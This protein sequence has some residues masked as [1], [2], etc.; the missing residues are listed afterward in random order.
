MAEL[1]ERIELNKLQGSDTGWG[2]TSRD[3]LLREG[4]QIALGLD[5]FTWEELG[6]PVSMD[7]LLTSE[8]AEAPDPT[9]D[10]LR[11]VGHA[12]RGLLDYDGATDAELI[13]SA[14]ARLNASHL[15][16]IPLLEVAALLVAAVEARTTRLGPEPPF[17]GDRP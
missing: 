10:V 14:R 15:G 13:E 17:P 5:R 2:G 8:T 9:R 11:R 7:L 3:P 6:R 4:P 12:R 1:R 16:T